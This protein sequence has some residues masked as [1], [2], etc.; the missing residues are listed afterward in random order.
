M[1]L[2]TLAATKRFRHTL[3]FTQWVMWFT[4]H[5]N[6][7]IERNGAVLIHCLNRGASH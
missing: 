3:V 6:G 4:G 2:L 7:L 1:L 5:S